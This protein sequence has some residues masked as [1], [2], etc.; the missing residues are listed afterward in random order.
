MKSTQIFAVSAVLTLCLAGCSKDRV[1]GPGTEFNGEV[2]YVSVKVDLE[3]ATR[4]STEQP[5]S[6]DESKLTEVYLVTFSQTGSVVANPDGGFYINLDATQLTDA[7]AGTAFTARV[8]GGTRK[9]MAVANPGVQMKAALN[10]LGSSSTF[11]SFNAVMSDPDTTW[12]AIIEVMDGTRGFAMISCKSDSSLAVGGTIADALIDVTPSVVGTAYATDALAIA[13]ALA[14][15]VEVSIERLA[16]KVFFKPVPADVEVL[17]AGATFAFDKWTV[18]ALNELITP[19]ST[20]TIIGSTHSTGGHYK[21]NFYTEDANYADVAPPAYHAGLAY[22]TINSTTKEPELPWNNYAT[23]NDDDTEK[24]LT[25]NTMIAAAQRYGNATRIVIKGQYAPV[26]FT[27][28]DDW[29]GFNGSK[30]EKFADL[31]AAFNAPGAS[32]EL[33]AAC[34]AFA[35]QMEYTGGFAAMTKHDLKSNNGGEWAKV[36]K[37][38]VGIRY[39]QDSLNYWF[40]EIRHDNE[41]NGTIEQNKYGVVRNNWYNCTLNKVSGPGTPWYPDLVDPGDGDPDPST[42][43]DE[44]YGYVGIEITPAP[45]IIWENGMT[46]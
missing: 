18:D 1:D 7:R 10:S 27:L 30:Y 3:K 12:G 35:T 23:W 46:I 42:P 45:W 19:F 22:A 16:S 9:I 40:Y 17:P 37:T 25:E 33:K 36:P 13:A 24:Y 29:F 34:E 38:G 26:G 41:A 20:K 32:A 14:S 8:G 6:T 28:G 39:Y 31:K 44:A 43:I 2:G 21:Y 11:G 4:G 5:A 15:P